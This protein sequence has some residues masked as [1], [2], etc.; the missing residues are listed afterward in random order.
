ME[1]MKRMICA[2]TWLLASWTASGQWKWDGEAGD[3]SW[4]SPA[5]WFPDGVPATGDDVL[6]DNSLLSIDYEVRVPAG[7]IS[8]SLDSLILRPGAGRS[9]RLVIPSTNKAA[10]ALSITGPGE[11]LRIDAGAVFINASGATS[12]EPLQPAGWMRIS[13]GGRYIHAT[14]RANARLIDRLSTEPGTSTG[15]FEFNVPGTSGY[16]VSLTGNT[17]G[18]LV[19]RSKAAGGLKSYSGSGSSDLYIRGNLV[20]DTGA[21]LTSTLTSN[22]RLDGHLLVNGL[23]S[24][25]PPTAG[26]S[27]RSLILMSPQNSLFE[28]PNIQWQQH[29]REIIIG[30]G[31]QTLLRS[32]LSLP[33]SGQKI[34]VLEKGTLSM[35]QFSVMGS[36]S[37]EL[38]AGGILRTG[39]PAGLRADGADGNIRTISRQLHKG[40][41]FVFDGSGDQQTGDGLPDTIAGLTIDKASGKLNLTKTTQVTSNLSLVQGRIIT[42]DNSLLDFS[43]DT[44]THQANEFGMDSCGGPSSFI[45][46]P[47]RRRINRMGKFGMPIGKDGIFRPLTLS[48]T[49]NGSMQCR[50]TYSNDAT[51]AAHSLSDP[52]IYQVNGSGY[53]TIQMENITGDSSLITALSWR[54]SGDSLLRKRWLDSLRIVTTNPDLSNGWKITGSQPNI[55]DQNVAGTLLSD[56]PIRS[57]CLMTFGTTGPPA[58]LPITGILLMARK[59]GNTTKLE[60]ETSGTSEAAHFIV[61]RNDARQ[62]IDTIGILTAMHTRD[63]ERFSMIDE[64][65]S[66]G[67]NTYKVCAT[68]KDQESSQCSGIVAVYHSSP[69]EVLLFPVP[70]ID[71][72]HWKLTGK[73]DPGWIRILDNKGVVQ[74]KARS[75]GKPEGEVDVDGW[76]PGIYHLIIPFNGTFIRRSFL[77]GN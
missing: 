65:P 5:N 68:E 69:S 76:S 67:W 45:D 34:R 73:P 77:K 53:W 43:G 36:G 18:S 75:D 40:G 42:S 59:M 70:A 50:V 66:P 51:P 22:I 49:G 33:F 6:L 26:G 61:H 20:V 21:G 11:S 64:H 3:S 54:F 74:W 56:Q 12:G 58:G 8:I 14:P 25:Q 23:L 39:H 28:G 55:V 9:I 15:I 48:R 37:L 31:H 35:G 24:F 7:M 44:I 71:R 62:R 32:N 60:W 47:F 17:F 1:N 16:T 27:G 38:N 52:N 4:T 30:P 63:N 72:L 46:G 19:F 13:D 29:F 41:S 2:M 10:P 57:S